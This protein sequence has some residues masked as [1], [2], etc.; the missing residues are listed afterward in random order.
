MGGGINLSCVCKSANF[1]LDLYY[2]SERFVKKVIYTFGMKKYMNL[3]DIEISK[4][5]SFYKKV[6]IW[7]AT[8]SSIISS[9]IMAVILH[10][11]CCEAHLRVLDIVLSVIVALFFGLFG[12]WLA[13]GLLFGGNRNRWINAFRIMRGKD[14]DIKCECGYHICNSER[15]DHNLCADYRYLDREQYIIR[16]PKCGEWHY[17]E[18]DANNMT[19]S[20]RIGVAIGVCYRVIRLMLLLLSPLLC[21][22]FALCSFITFVSNS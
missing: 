6:T 16:C 9:V 21:A 3:H 7:A 18:E 12:L 14:V 13:L 20:K 4:L 17:L 11:R 10:F 1:C 8:L 2:S 15:I 19:F 5:K 22:F